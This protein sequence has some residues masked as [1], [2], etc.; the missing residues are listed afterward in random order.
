MVEYFWNA[1]IAA[2][3]IST[4]QYTNYGLSFSSTKSKTFSVKV[5]CPMGEQ[6]Q[7]RP[8]T[9]QDFLSLQSKFDDFGENLCFLEVKIFSGNL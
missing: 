3:V 5:N 7:P 4:N 1:S 9:E 2:T 6:L 8:I